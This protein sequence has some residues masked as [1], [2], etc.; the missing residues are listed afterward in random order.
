MPSADA[1]IQAL[2]RRMRLHA[3][4][5]RGHDGVPPGWDGWFALPRPQAVTAGQADAIVA[6]LT[7]RPPRPVP[8]A[9][10]DPGRWGAF[11]AVWRQ[12]WEPAEP[13]DRPLRV[14]AGGFS[15]FLHLLLGAAM[16]W[17]LLTG[18]DPASATRLGDEDVVQ[19]EFIGDGV[20]EEVG[21][22]ATEPAAESP[23]AATPTPAPVTAPAAPANVASA[24]A[25][26]PEEPTAPPA[27]PP[28]VQAPVPA[29][30]VQ[31]AIREPELAA[32]PVPVPVEREIPMP[33]VREQPLQVSE[34]VPDTSTEFLLPPPTVEI[35]QTLPTPEL[36]AAQRQA[37]EREIPTPPRRLA[38][39]QLSQ[40]EFAGPALELPATTAD[41]R[42]VPMPATPLPPGPQVRITSAGVSQPTLE[43][44]RRTA[45]ERPVP[46]PDVARAAEGAAQEA[47]SDTS[48][49][50]APA[51]AASE[52]DSRDPEAP[53]EAVAAGPRPTAAPGGWSDPA[54]GDD[55]AASDQQRDG[56]QAGQPAG[57]FDSDGRIRLAET[58]GS[59]T[60]GD[61]PGTVTEEIANLD[62]AGTWLRRPP[63]DYEPTSLD[64]FWRPNETLLEEWVRRSVTTV[65][66]PIPGSSKTIVCQT[67]LLAMG[68]GCGIE[69]PNMVDQP[70]SARPP[71]D[72]P[73]KPELQ[74]GDGAA[75]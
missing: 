61:P 28:D 56:G 40:Q 68:G 41:E 27:G 25:D 58:P 13:E 55:W 26:V 4:R 39:R 36:Q 59:S 66:I 42:Q 50:E 48:A 33:A 52:S 72:I 11:A 45:R 21:G 37:V 53:G 47:A 18:Y 43:P 73:F 2:Q 65:R 57:L 14:F 9:A 64:R 22:G 34:P 62:R 1:Y 32:A 38:P 5:T 60:T 31:P 70:A 46:M 30:Q 44:S 3:Y 29:F 63:N 6:Q 8:P 49:P 24:A 54:R 74:E 35:E 16:V 12:Q 51:V 69:D 10:T 15:L 19:V 67:V 17:L 23:A 71:P 7:A 75:G 20:P